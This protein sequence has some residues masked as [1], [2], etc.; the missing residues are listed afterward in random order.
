MTGQWVN[1]SEQQPGLVKSDGGSK[2][3]YDVVLQ[4]NETDPNTGG[5]HVQQPCT[6]IGSMQTTLRSVSGPMAT[7]PDIKAQVGKTQTSPV[8]GTREGG[9]VLLNYDRRALRL[10]YNGDYLYGSPS[11]FDAGSQATW[12]Y[13]FNLKRR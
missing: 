6:F 10:T 5:L 1:G 7:N 2:W 3:N 12:T 11:F 4:I 13:T 9:T 8:S